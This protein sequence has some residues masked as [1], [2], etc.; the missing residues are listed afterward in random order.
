MTHGPDDEDLVVTAESIRRDAKRI[1]E[2]EARK[3]ED[4]GGPAVPALTAEAAALASRVE[5]GTRAEQAIVR[6]RP[7][8]SP[9]N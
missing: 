5:D 6:D 8:R 7:R 9:P 1:A 2:I 4:P 3:L